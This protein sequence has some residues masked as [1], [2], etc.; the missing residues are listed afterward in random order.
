MRQTSTLVHIL[1]VRCDKTAQ[2][3]KSSTAVPTDKLPGDVEVVDALETDSFQDFL[4]TVI[5]CKIF[6]SSQYL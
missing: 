5:I 1:P 3:S 6:C 4:K 2:K